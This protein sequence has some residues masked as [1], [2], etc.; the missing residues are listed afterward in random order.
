MISIATAADASAETMKSTKLEMRF[1]A[2]TREP[3]DLVNLETGDRLVLAPE[4]AFRLE[5]YQIGKDIATLAEDIKQKKAV[6]LALDARDCQ[7]TGATQKTS[8]DGA[9]IQTIAYNG[10]QGKVT[11]TY[12]LG[13][14]DHFIEKAV[15][16]TPS[17]TDSYLLWKVHAGRFRLTD[18]PKEYVPFVHGSCLTHLVRGERTSFLFGVQVPTLA[19]LTGLNVGKPSIIPE[20]VKLHFPD[21]HEL[22]YAVNFRYA[23]G[24]AYECEK[25]F[26]STA[27]LNGRFSP[28]V[29]SPHNGNNGEDR[30]S[31]VPPDLGESEAM[32]AMVRR[33]APPLRQGIKVTM[34][35]WESNLTR[36]GYGSKAVPQEVESDKRILTAAKENLGRYEVTLSGVWGGLH[37]EVAQLTPSAATPPVTPVAQGMLDWARSQ[38]IGINM[39]SAHGGPNPWFNMHQYCP[40]HSVWQAKGSNC[41]CPTNRDYMDWHFNLVMAMIRRGYTSYAEDEHYALASGQVRC[42]STAHDH[43]PGN[44][45]YGWFR[46]RQE[47]YR[48][49]RKEFGKDFPIHGYRPQ[50]D[51]GI[52]ECLPVDNIFTVNESPPAGGDRI[53]NWSRIRHDYHFTPGYMDQALINRYTDYDMLSALAVSSTYLFYGTGNAT[54][55]KWLT[56]A[57][58]HPDHMQGQSIFLPD[59]PGNGKCDAY[60]R[61]VKGSGF[62]FLFNGNKA[63]A[64]AE[65]PLDAAVGLNPAKTYRLVCIHP[66]EKAAE[67]IE[68][69]GCWR[70]RLPPGAA[71]LMSIQ[72][73]E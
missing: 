33:L 24:E 38:E 61:L 22:G 52:W 2:Q 19:P 40:Q 28:K 36:N 39:W 43:L 66:V 14:E 32:L 4:S 17:F 56:W 62:A 72:P 67:K 27:R 45:S 16:F 13:R 54:A 41:T 71:W 9:S 51:L 73:V 25:V 55:K 20:E 58:E 44:A 29:P 30:Q 63:E 65:L 1:D 3:A 7:V 69:Q 5:F 59:W 60:L 64:E 10:A 34:N 26:W 37:H 31:E 12:T 53:R 6:L 49:L 23:V 47:L 46:L 21:A 48:T 50:M 15:R 70:G 57:R 18:K 42:N 68:A 35:G 11:V 8:P